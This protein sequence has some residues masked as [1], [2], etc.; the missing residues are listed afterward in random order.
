MWLGKG[1]TGFCQDI[2]QEPLT[3][4]MLYSLHHSA[5]IHSFRDQHTFCCLFSNS[6]MSDSSETPQTVG[7]QA[8]LTIG[9]SKQDYWNGLPF[10]SPGDLPD[11][12]T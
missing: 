8:P 7:S 2:S 11:P 12:G 3:K 1:S 6:V 5:F 4:P 9:F 10:P